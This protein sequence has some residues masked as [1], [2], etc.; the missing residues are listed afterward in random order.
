MPCFRFSN[1]EETWRSRLICA[2]QHW[3]GKFENNAS[4]EVP[5]LSGCSINCST[6]DIAVIIYVCQ[7]YLIGT[8]D[9]LHTT[10]VRK[11]TAKTQEV[12]SPDSVV[13]KEI[14]YFRFILK[15]VL[16][17]GIAFTREA[18]I[19]AVKKL[20]RPIVISLFCTS[21]DIVKISRCVRTNVTN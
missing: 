10:S 2:G 13:L 11:R 18:S 5:R 19:I 1:M 4:V 21:R 3:T 20:C 14:V 8:H 15:M 12:S 6:K 9:S 7:Y 16:R 17:R